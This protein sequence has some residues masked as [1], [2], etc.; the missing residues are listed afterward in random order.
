MK[1]ILQMDENFP[2]FWSGEMARV[3][4]NCITGIFTNRLKV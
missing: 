1:T 3:D 4:K 2:Q